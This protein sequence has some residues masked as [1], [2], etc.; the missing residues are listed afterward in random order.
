[1]AKSL[2]KTYGDDAVAE[3]HG[4]IPEGERTEVRQTFQDPDSPLRFLVLQVDTGGVGL[5]FTAADKAYYLSNGFSLESRLQSEARNH[6][7]G[8]E[9]HNRI[10]YTDVVAEDTLDPKVL[11]TLREK[12]S[13]A[14]VITGDNW[15]EWV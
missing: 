8:S 4:G 6:R 12:L 13:L 14:N 3:F 7:A 11:H 10:T 15:R 5:T 1:M 9:V 2:R